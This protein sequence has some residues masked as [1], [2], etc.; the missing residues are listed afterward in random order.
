MILMVAK[1]KQIK[2][3]KK[4]VSAKKAIKKKAVAKKKVSKSPFPKT[5]LGQPNWFGLSSPN[6]QAAASFYEKVLGLK[7]EK[8]KMGDEQM[9]VL[10]AGANQIAHIS[11]VEEGA[12]P[13]WIVFFYS[14]DVDKATKLC[15]QNG[16]KV[17]M[18]PVDIP[19]GRIA[20]LKDAE[21]AE[22]ALFKPHLL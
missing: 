2:S 13:R 8:I 12:G 3:K 4:L 5:A 6:E 15:E 7:S 16:G 11:P 17:V 19:P 1:K 22:F 20:F 10:K 21:G 9:I 18:P 14:P